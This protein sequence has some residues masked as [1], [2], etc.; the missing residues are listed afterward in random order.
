MKKLFVLAVGIALVSFAAKADLYWESN[1]TQ[2]ADSN[3]PF[4][5]SND[6]AVGDFLQLIYSPSGVPQPFSGTGTGVTGSDLVWATGYFGQDDD[7]LETPGSFASHL[8]VS[9]TAPGGG[10]AVFYVRGYDGP[11]PN[12]GDG[13]SAVIPTGAKVF[14][15]TA[16]ISY[17]YN[18][19]APDTVYS[20]DL[21]AAVPEPAMVSLFLSGLGSLYMLRRK[22]K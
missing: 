12:F 19:T 9:G 21:V 8:A 4:T 11:A 18:P 6:P 5:M 2:P 22:I 16:T 15:S 10:T 1:G 14:Q 17:T 7:L 13:T 20:F 3:P